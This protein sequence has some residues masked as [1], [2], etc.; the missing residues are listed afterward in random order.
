MEEPPLTPSERRLPQMESKG[1]NY[2][3]PSHLAVPHW[4]M[5]LEH[6]FS[7]IFVSEIQ[8]VCTQFTDAFVVFLYHLCRYLINL[9]TF[10]FLSSILGHFFHF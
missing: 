6:F 9:F 3:L 5:L 10:I 2:C 4:D 1:Q 7:D 8:K